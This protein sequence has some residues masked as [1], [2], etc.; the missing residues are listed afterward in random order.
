MKK[1]SITD[2]TFVSRINKIKILNVVR[3][4]GGTTRPGIARE[5]GLSLPTVT[6]L[7]ESLIHQEKLIREKGS[8]EV[9]RGRP[10][11]LLEFSGDNHYVVGLS[12]GANH[13]SGILTDLNAR[14]LTHKE[15][16]TRPSRGYR[17]LIRAV[18][19]LILD[20][21]RTSRI[22]EG[23]LL[24]VGIAIGGLIDKRRNVIQYSAIFDWEEKDLA[25]DLGE[26]IHKPIRF[27]HT[28]RVMALGELCYGIGSQIDNFVCV[29]WGYG[30]GAAFIQ[31]GKPFYG[32]RG[33]AGEFGHIPVEGQSDIPCQCGNFGCLEALASGW[34]IANAAMARLSQ[35]TSSLLLQLCG[36]H[37]ERITAR[38]VA[39]AAAQGDT[40][41]REILDQACDYMGMGLATLMNLQNPQAIILGGG[42]MRSENLVLDRVKQAAFKHSLR[43]LR[44]DIIIQPV[45][46]GDHCKTMG[47]VSLILNEVLN[48]NVLHHP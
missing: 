45:Q 20:L 46:L 1:D 38:L 17:A 30:I 6:R 34:G 24:G 16:P 14:I 4:N 27:D 23:D 39:Q 18:A 48:L 3:N 8:G 2:T 7:V 36:N 35:M 44:E 5:L 12:I 9:A 28:A 29:L 22:D 42:I 15:V 11:K 47:A 13:I 26:L 33:M 43:N 10:P 40:M 25:R 37:P 19:R 32:T 41:C 21:I 31:E